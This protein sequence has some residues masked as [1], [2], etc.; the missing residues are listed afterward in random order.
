LHLVEA[1]LG[2]R[3]FD[4]GD[5]LDGLVITEELLVREAEPALLALDAIR[6]VED[7]ER[8]GSAE[9]PGAGDGVRSERVGR[10]SAEHGHEQVEVVDG[11]AD[12]VPGEAARGEQR[13]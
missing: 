9:H 6:T 7:P 2:V 1:R 10:P 12:A 8:M 11:A 3:A 5:V 4:R 13:E